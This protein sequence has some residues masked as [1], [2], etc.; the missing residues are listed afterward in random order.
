MKTPYIKPVFAVELF[1]GAQ[2]TTRDCWDSII[3]ED[4]TLNDLPDCYWEPIPGVRLFLENTVCTE[5]GEIYGAACYNN[6]SETQYIFR[7]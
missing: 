7:S 4:V 6:P 2:T 3:A 5:N 1:S